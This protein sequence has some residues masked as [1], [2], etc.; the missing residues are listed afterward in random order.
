MANPFADLPGAPPAGD[1]GHQLY[2][3]P[4]GMVP[5]AKPFTPVLIDHSK[6][7]PEQ[8]HEWQAVLR[9]GTREAFEQF[10]AKIAEN[11]QSNTASPPNA[12][13]LAPPAAA[14]GE[15]V[16]P[17]PERAVLAEKLAEHGSSIEMV[18][19]MEAPLARFQEGIL[20]LPEGERGAAVLAGEQR[21]IEGL[22]RG[23]EGAFKAALGEIK[24][25]ALAV[26]GA[27]LI[28]QIDD[29]AVLA[30]EDLF[31]R[32]WTMARTVNSGAAA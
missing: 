26:G 6:L 31:F 4:G 20:A 5:D 2:Q 8:R 27:D 15:V 19:A 10:A 9:S 23:S 24:Q 14:G 17:D 13:G 22:F 7:T 25:A 29:S 32:V 16:P 11:G 21:V 12:V 18:D 1:P 3:S 28:R 30:D